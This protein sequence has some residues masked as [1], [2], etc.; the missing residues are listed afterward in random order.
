MAEPV[1]EPILWS[2]LKSDI[3]G[4]SRFVTSWRELGFRNYNDAIKAAN[5]LGGRRYHNR[6]YGGGLVFTS[7][8]VNL[9]TLEA[10]LKLAAA[11][12]P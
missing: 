1:P 5:Q 3:K 8:K 9:P 7:L 2:R 12:L 6:Q 11:A 10:Q 4:D